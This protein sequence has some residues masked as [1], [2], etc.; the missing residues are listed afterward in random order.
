[1]NEVLIKAPLADDIS[2]GSMIRQPYRITMAR[3][4]CDVH[5][6][7]ILTAI[8]ATLQKEIVWVEKG[9]ALA[10]LAIFGSPGNCIR[11]DIPM[12]V[13]NPSGNNYSQVHKTLQ[14]LEEKGIEMFLPEVKGRKGPPV[15]GQML[16]FRVRRLPKKTN[17]IVSLHIEKTLLIELLRTSSGLTGLSMDVL[18][19]LR[20]PYSIRLYEI[21]SHWKDR[22][23]FRASLEQLRGWLGTGG[24]L[25][26]T[27]EFLRKVVNPSKRQ[28]ER[29]SD[30]YFEFTPERTANR[31]SHLVFRI[32][33]KKNKEAEELV[34]MQLREQIQQVLRIRFRW[35]E[36]QFQEIRHLLTDERCLRRINE[37]IARLW[38]YHDQFPD[39]IRNLPQW[40]LSALLKD[41]KASSRKKKE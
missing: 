9:A 36:D 40:S 35:K 1:M 21:L 27:R 17:H 37:K 8:I 32:L 7:R 34:I 31:I 29:M 18:F 22:E 10:D 23:T 13:L 41:E 14:F 30:V 11:I 5:Q 24:K 38:Q 28:L 16:L 15:N 20:S 3:W 39:E 26:E 4:D 33:Q 12:K 2:Y 6:K 25:M 19:R